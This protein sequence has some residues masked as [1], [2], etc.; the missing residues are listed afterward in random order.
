MSTDKS[1]TS[2]PGTS[3]SNDRKPVFDDAGIGVGSAD[4]SEHQRD[5]AVFNSMPPP[6]NPNRDKGDN[7]KGGK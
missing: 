3:T 6:R 4:Y 2:R 1:K 7:D 5:H